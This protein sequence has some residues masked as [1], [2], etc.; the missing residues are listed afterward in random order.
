MWLMP[1]GWFAWVGASLRKQNQKHVL[2]LF[3]LCGWLR[4]DHRGRLYFDATRAGHPRAC[5]TPMTFAVLAH[6]TE[7]RTCPEGT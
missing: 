2:V 3:G 1:Y 7:F 6:V 5:A 4:R